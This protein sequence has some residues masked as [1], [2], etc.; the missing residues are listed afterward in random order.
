M[1]VVDSLAMSKMIA[2]D[3][4]LPW[5]LRNREI[6]EVYWASLAATRLGVIVVLV[7]GLVW[8]QI[9]GAQFL[10]VEMGLLSFTAVAQCA[11]VVFIG[12]YW[13]RGSRRGAFAGISLGFALWCYTLILPAL[14][15]GEILPVSLLT[16]GPFGIAFLRPTALLGLGGLDPLAHGVFWSLLCNVGAYLVVSALTVQDAQERSQAAAFVGE[17][18]VKPAGRPAI[19]SVPEIERLIHLYVPE[20]A[21]ESVLR[22][23]FEGKTADELTVSELL[24]GR[25]RLE[26]LLAASL[27]GAAAH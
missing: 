23:L 1:I 5:V 22:D 8:A 14:V 13:R 2:N 3:V 17:A 19:L 15:K 18:E 25:V 12:L 21:S 11:P 27:G 7:L 10:L 9:E 4:V 24:E 6:A 16:E 20:D 26:R